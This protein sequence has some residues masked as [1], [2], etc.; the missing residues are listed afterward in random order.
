MNCFVSAAFVLSMR[1][2]IKLT[3]FSDWETLV[4]NN[5][6]SIPPLIIFSFVFE[7][8]SHESLVKNL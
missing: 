7:D 3:G 6:L 5:L 4:Y 1:K 2:R 8:W